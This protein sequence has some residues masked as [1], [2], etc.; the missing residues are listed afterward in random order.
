MPIFDAAVFVATGPLAV[1]PPLRQYVCPIAPVM[2]YVHVNAPELPPAMDEMLTGDGPATS[3]SVAPP[4]HGISAVGATF[5]SAEVPL[6]VTIILTDTVWPE[7]TLEGVT[8]RAA[9]KPP[10]FTVLEFVRTEEAV[11][12]EFCALALK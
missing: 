8:E 12:P 1:A 9:V 11:P 4:A 10:M 7:I 6:L 2:V 5:T 3:V